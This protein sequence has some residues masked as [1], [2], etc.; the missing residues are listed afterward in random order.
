[1]QSEL[2]KI[3]NVI[4]VGDDLSFTLRLESEIP[5]EKFEELKRLG[6]Q[7]KIYPFKKAIRFEKGFL[8]LDGKFL[9]ISRD[10]DRKVLEEAL[11]ILFKKF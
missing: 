10:L 2:Q 9:R 7:C 1:M 6:K 8:A 5:V 4:A 11:E 3:E